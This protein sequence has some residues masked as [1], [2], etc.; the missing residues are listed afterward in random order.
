MGFNNA[1]KG[2]PFLVLTDLDKSD[3]PPVLINEWFS[4]QKNHNLIFRIAVREVESWLLAD[5]NGFAK[6]IRIRE[7]L[8]PADVENIG[9]PKQFLIDLVRKSPKTTLK[10][11]IIPRER[12][13]AKTG[14]NYNGRLVDFVYHGWNIRTAQRNSHSLDKTVAA[15]SKFIPV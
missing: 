3:C 8:I 14:P 12:S 13:T 11:D 7:T 2:T 5:R 15:L 1:A 6:F 9:D 10:N 4:G